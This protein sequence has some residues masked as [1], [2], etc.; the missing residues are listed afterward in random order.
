MSSSVLS[1]IKIR[2][3]AEYLQLGLIKQIKLLQILNRS[4]KFTGEVIFQKYVN[5]VNREN[6]KSLSLYKD[7]TRL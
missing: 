2:G 3:E 6:G 5:C 1:D 4:S 7:M